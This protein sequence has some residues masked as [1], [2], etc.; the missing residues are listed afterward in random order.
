MFLNEKL[1]WVLPESMTTSVHDVWCRG[2][3]N[4]LVVSEQIISKVKKFCFGVYLP[5]H[6]AI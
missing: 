4:S 5:F 3:Y 2:H 6:L 1:A